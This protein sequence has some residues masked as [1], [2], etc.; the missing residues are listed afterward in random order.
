VANP[1]LR[2]FRSALLWRA[3]AGIHA[4]G[5]RLPLSV[6]RLLGR[7]LGRLAHATLRRARRDALQR[8]AIAFPE[9]SD[10]KRA[11]V[12]AAMF[13]H[14]GMSLFEIFWLPNLNANGDLTMRERT[15]IVEN[16]DAVRAHLENGRGVVAFTGHCG[17]WEW[18]AY[19]MATFGYPV[20][21]LQRERREGELN[22]FITSIRAQAGIRTIDRGT[23]ASGRELIQAVRRAGFLAF[24]IDQNI[25]T[26]SVRV[27]F[28]GR[29]ALTPI[30]PA[31]LAIRAESIAVPVF[32]ERRGAMQI[33]RFL[34]PI[35]CRRDD[36]PIALTALLTR[37][38]EEQ[39]R[40][41]PE[42]WVWMHD[43][44]KERPRWDIANAAQ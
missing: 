11:G 22:R 23:T 15:T 5:R 37:A 42:Q 3:I 17:N 13:R 2:A 29:P 6:A 4:V 19:T 35:D 34:E 33:I 41:V 8:V 32:I 28:F 14:L 39:I 25:R 40:R 10:R 7:A 21:V 20:A 27:P 1:K 18:L 9:W 26:E 36:D 16:F 31:R 12:I 24:L 38:I 43:R 44:W 30:G